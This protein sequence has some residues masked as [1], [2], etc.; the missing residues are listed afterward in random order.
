MK[1]LLINKFWYPHGGADIHAIQLAALLEKQGIE[2]GFFG[3]HHPDNTEIDEMFTRYFVPQRHNNKAAYETKGNLLGKISEAKQIIYASDAARNLE[4]LLQEFRPDIAHIHNFYHHLSPSI[5]R[6]LKKYNIPTVQTL[7]DYKRICP[8]H[9]LY[10]NN[11]I[12]RK[13]KTGGFKEAIKNKCIFDARVPS[14]VVATEMYIQ[15]IFGWYD[16]F[17]EYIAPSAFMKQEMVAWGKDE[18]NISVIPNWVLPKSAVGEKGSDV[19]YVGGLVQQKGVDVVLS[20]ARAMPH[21]TFHVMGSGIEKERIQSE[22]AMTQL[23]NVV[24]HG[25]KTSE[26]MQKIAQ[27][28]CVTLVPSRLLDN[29][30]NAVLE[31]FARGIPVVGS[32][33]GG[34]PEMI[35]DGTT[36]FVC[37]T[38]E[39]HEWVTAIKKAQADASRVMG[40]NARLIAQNRYNPEKI[41]PRIIAL[42]QQTIHLKGV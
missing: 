19:L 35:E 6:I 33:M 39:T 38:F 14:A 24:L 18:N 7:H 4:K 27:T 28:C 8:N 12:C 30:P 36:G 25:V 9:A 41:I 13:C 2:V 20:C 40:K 5:V 21:T 42:Y 23:H 15:K 16:S 32:S 17:D 34:I 3:M 11:A 26:E 31:S 22:V 29:F 37:K 1:V 10:V